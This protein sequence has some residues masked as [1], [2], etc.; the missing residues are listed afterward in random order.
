MACL[1]Q[2]G[3]TSKLYSHIKPLDHLD[4]RNTVTATRGTEFA[5]PQLQ[6]IAQQLPLQLLDILHHCWW[7]H[8]LHHS[9]LP[10]LW[11]VPCRPRLELQI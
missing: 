1:L 5:A 9:V 6:D 4:F 7:H 2:Q 11:R 10:L 8:R 3:P